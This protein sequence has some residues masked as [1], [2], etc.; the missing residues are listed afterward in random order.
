[1]M[2]V[3]AFTQFE[4]K[5]TACI[6]EMI[7]ISNTSRAAN[8]YYWNFCSGNLYYPPEGET[9]P[10]AGTINDPAFIDFAQDNGEWFSFITN[11]NDGSVTRNY[12]GSD[13]LSTPVSENLGDFG[14]IIP[15]HVQGIQVV[16][17][18]GNWYVFVVGGQGPDSRL[19]RLDFGNSLSNPN[20]VATN[21]GNFTGQLDYWPG[22]RPDHGRGKWR[23]VRL[24]RKF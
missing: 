4:V 3:T 21:L 2:P 23:M 6:D 19:V 7:T 11:H 22:H 9:L 10:D 15:Q 20:P 8:S 1:M 14:G 5:D 12:Y 24:Y 18:D 17:D 13:I 16:N